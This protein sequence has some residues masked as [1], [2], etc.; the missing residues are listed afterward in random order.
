[1]RWLAL[2]LPLCSCGLLLD[3]AYLIGSK[4][5]TKT[6]DQR[7]PTGE[8]QV[9]P[10]LKL[11]YDG[12]RLKVACESVTHSVDRVWS[13]DKV[14]EYQGGLYQ[15]HWAP[16]IIEGV[17]GSALAIGFGIKCADPASD[18]SC[19]TLYA[20]I[21]FGVDVAYSIVRLLTIDPPKLVDK[22]TSG[23]RV[24]TNG[25]VLRRETVACPSDTTVAVL[26]G[27][28]RELVDANG[29]LAPGAQQRIELAMGD[30]QAVVAVV[31]AEQRS[32]D[33]N[34]C[35]FYALRPASIRGTYVPPE[36]GGAAR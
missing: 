17:I 9:A 13:V 25:T 7:R 19:S 10:E 14:Y 5:T 11:A 15:A 30:P 33:L 20:T 24:D 35:E 22:H 8:Q 1:M 27:K 28:A 4:Q 21:P 23:T 34:H 16:V 32:S 26:N 29:E 31:A 12:P 3:G 2:L 18:F 36:C 6:E